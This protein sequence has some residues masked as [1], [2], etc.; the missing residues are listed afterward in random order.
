MGWA[1]QM[2]LSHFKEGLLYVVGGWTNPFIDGHRSFHNTIATGSQRC[3]VKNWWLGLEFK[4][5]GTDRIMPLLACLYSLAP[6]IG[7]RVGKPAIVPCLRDAYLYKLIK[8]GIKCN[9][10][11]SSPEMIWRWKVLVV[12][13][14]P[15]IWFNPGLKGHCSS[16]LPLSVVCRK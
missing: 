14:I 7:A 13:A 3:H 6:Q 5:A 12:G 16:I 4:L 11:A 1:W 9:Q 15:L 2:E 8:W 10:R